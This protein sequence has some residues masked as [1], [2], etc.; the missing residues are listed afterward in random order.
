[1]GKSV[2]WFLGHKLLVLVMFIIILFFVPLAI[3]YTYQMHPYFI[4]IWG[5]DDVLLYW[6]NIL[7]AAGA[8]IGI[9][10][11]AE[12]AQSNFQE[13]TRK[14]QLPYLALEGLKIKAANSEQ[15]IKYF[16]NK[17]NEKLTNNVSIDSSES[18][19]INS[20]KE[21]IFIISAKSIEV[22]DSLTT[23]QQEKLVYGNFAQGLFY[24]DKS[25]NAYF[26]KLMENVG[27]G[28]A[29]ELKMRMYD[30]ENKIEGSNFTNSISLK[31]GDGFRVG[32][33][34]EKIDKIVEDKNYGFEVLYCDIYHNK[35]KQLLNISVEQ[36][37]AFKIKEYKYI[38]TVNEDD[39]KQEQVEES[40]CSKN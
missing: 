10:V 24:S 16:V 2:N 12:Q 18:G 25:K 6:G 32:L 35:Y 23:E 38:C 13:D 34:F 5:A 37:N 40:F 31:V 17:M 26:F 22:T 8:F 28:A 7:C 33:C 29:V 4:T 3:N 27:N 11:T 1:M 15:S 9:Y 39:F 36:K 21:Y 30:N 19:C 14:R 20:V